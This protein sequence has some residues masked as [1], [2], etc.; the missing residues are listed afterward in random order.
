[1][2]LVVAQKV[3]G[4]VI[5][6]SPG[7]SPAAKAAPCNAAVPELKLTACRA[8]VHAAN[9]S[10]NSLI[11]G[12]VVSQSDFRTL[13]TACTSASST[14]CLPY[15]NNLSRTG[16]PPWM[17]SVSNFVGKALMS[18]G[19]RNRIRSARF[20]RHQFFQLTPRQ[21]AFVAVARIPE[22]FRKRLSVD[23][24]FRLPPRMRRLNYE[25]T[26][27]LER[28]SRLV[29][30]DQHFVQLLSRTNPDV[31][32]LASGR[33]RFRQVHQPHAGNLRNKNL[34]AVHLLQA[35]DDKLH[36]LLQRQPESSHSRIGDRDLPAP[37]LIQ[38]NRDDAAVAAHH[39]PVARTTEAGIRASIRIGLHKHFFCAQFGGAIQ[40]DRINRLVGAE[41]QNAAHALIN[42]RINHVAPA[43]DICLDRFERVVLASR[44]LLERRRVHHHRHARESAL[45]PLDVPH[46]SNEIPHAGMIEARRSHLMLLQ[47]VPAENHQSSRLVVAQHDLHKLLPERTCSTRYQYRFLRPTRHSCSFEPSSVDSRAELQRGT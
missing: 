36:A 35:A 2:Q 42:R 31:L 13:T 40:I 29:F 18:G 37:A 45:Q 12:P 4:V 22:T 43:H 9:R 16:V 47:L 30:R 38:K 34:A 28:L 26:L 14:L 23:P 17:A 46:V 25:H 10:S 19:S 5:A 27:S 21:P 3:M 1:M 41:R 33:N 8:P 6:S 15:G 11:F 32:D 44:H 20:R 24:I 39:V 7:P